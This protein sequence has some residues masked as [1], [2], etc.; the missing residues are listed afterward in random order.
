MAKKQFIYNHDQKIDENIRNLGLCYKIRY[1]LN[2]SFGEETSFGVEKVGDYSFRTLDNPL[3]G[4]QLLRKAS[5]SH[6]NAIVNSQRRIL[7][8]NAT[9]LYNHPDNQE[10]KYWQDFDACYQMFLVKSEDS[11]NEKYS[12]EI[13]SE[14]NDILDDQSDWL[15][16][17]EATIQEVADAVLCYFLTR[18][19]N[20]DTEWT[21][22]LLTC[23]T[24]ESQKA[25][26]EFMNNQIGIETKTKEDSGSDN[27][28]MESPEDTTA[29][30]A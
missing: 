24:E 28:G 29:P 6:I 7:L 8:D 25:L 21:L 13:S 10:N 19:S 11:G 20:D 27:K 9:R 16:E 12:A 18:R 22:E 14:I 15:E 17:C 5:V 3:V 26:R 23:Q 2:Y 30:K 4:E 1:G